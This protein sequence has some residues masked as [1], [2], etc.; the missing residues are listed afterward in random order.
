MSETRFNCADCGKH[1]ITI[2]SGAF[3]NRMVIIC[4]QC[5]Q[6]RIMKEMSPGEAIPEFLL[7]FVNRG[8][9]K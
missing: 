9:L 2:K 4:F 3:R 8:G 7:G 5:D 6:K 1:M